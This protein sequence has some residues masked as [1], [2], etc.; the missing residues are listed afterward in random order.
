M[1]YD[2]WALESQNLN[3]TNKKQNVINSNIN[4][5]NAIN[6]FYPGWILGSKCACKGTAAAGLTTLPSVGA[7]P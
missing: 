6:W 7:I 5:L 3:Q 1:Y 4:I 2:H